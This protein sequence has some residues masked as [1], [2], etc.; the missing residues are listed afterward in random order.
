MDQ[1][2]YQYTYLQMFLTRESGAAI[3]T[4]TGASDVISI[5]QRD[6][7]DLPDTVQVTT[8]NVLAS[9]MEMTI[10]STDPGDYSA[11]LLKM[12]VFGCL[13]Y[14]QVV[15]NSM[16]VDLTNETEKLMLYLARPATN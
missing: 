1:I 6:L 8:G 7:S 11:N 2:V 16:F 10:K 4:L 13:T 3:L 12:A 5:V 15:P 9:T 14:F